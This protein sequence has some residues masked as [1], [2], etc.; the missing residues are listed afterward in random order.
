MNETDKVILCGAYLDLLKNNEKLHEILTKSKEGAKIY[1]E[2]IHTILTRLHVVLG[3]EAI[4]CEKNR[5]AELYEQCKTFIN[6]NK[7]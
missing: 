3:A 4:E 1:Q 2:S 7:I 5:R 6:E